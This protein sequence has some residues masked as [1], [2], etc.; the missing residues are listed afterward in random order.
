MA[1]LLLRL[2]NSDYFSPHLALLRTY[3]DHVGITYYLI[4]KLCEDFPQD[5]VEF[6][7]PQYCHLLVTKP[8]AS[9][10][11]ECFLLRKCEEDVHIAL[12]TLWYIQAQLADLAD[13]P[14]SAAFRTCQRVYNRCQCIL[15]EDPDP[16]AGTRPR[17]MLQRFLPHF[18][19][20]KRVRPENVSSALVGIGA[21]LIGSPGC[22]SA[23]AY[24]G[25]LALQQGRRAPEGIEAHE[26]WIPET[27]T[28]LAEPLLAPPPSLVHVTPPKEHD[29]VRDAFGQEE[30]TR[31]IPVAASASTPA[32][33]SKPSPKYTTAS[34]SSVSDAPA[35]D[36]NSYSV[37][38]RKQYLRTHYGRT[39]TQ[40]LQALQDITQ[41]LQPL[42]K[43][44]RLSALRAELTALNHK[45][46]TELC[47]PTWCA[48]TPKEN[49]P[50]ERH[51]RVVRISASEAVVL[52]SAD[53]VPYLIHVEVLCNDLD[54]DP[55]RRY[56]RE[57]LQWL[58][59]NTA[60]HA[61]PLL[62]PRKDTQA[63]RVAETVQ[64]RPPS[65]ARSEE[66]DLTEQ[67]YGSDLAAFGAETA[68]GDGDEGMGEKNHALDNEAWRH[69]ESGP[70]QRVPFS[71]DEYAERMR[72]AA[73]MLAQL[74]GNTSTRQ[75][76]AHIPATRAPQSWSS[77]II[78]TPAAPDDEVRA[79]A[80][81]AHVLSMDTNKIRQR[82]MD[83]MAALEEER[84][85][86][87]KQGA[88]SF[89]R[90]KRNKF[91]AEDE[92]AVYRAVNKEDPSAAYF[93]ESWTTK[94]ERIRSLSPYGHLP[95][96]DLFSV[97]VKTGADLRQE[98]FAVQLIQEFK[99]VWQDCGSRCWVHYF[100]IVVL[101]E[102][103]GLIETIKDAVSVHSI[104]K[105]AYM[106]QM[107]G[108]AIASFSLYDHFV[109]TYGEPHTPRFR[110][111]R[112][113]FTESLAGYAIVS[114]L[115]QIKDRHN[116]NILVDT[117]GH[118]IHID[119]GFILGISPGGVGFEAAPF[120]L[121][122]EYIDIM[123][124]MESDGFEDFRTL[125]RQ[126]F[127]D[128]RKHAERFIVLVEL[129]QKDSKLPCF[130]LRDLAVANL[131]DRFQLTLTAEQCNEFVDRLI[132]SSAGSAFTRLYDQYQNFTQQIL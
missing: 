43:P 45:L 103:G 9:R 49:M 125:M 32:L 120:K 102:S 4:S 123:G 116:G 63:P 61:A 23:G 14:G 44:A 31:P 122:R 81:A 121:P 89:G 20:R 79:S 99:R 132:L 12:I 82:I 47:F 54:F 118:L 42:P 71:M 93:R 7:W 52:N 100:R 38:V 15:F 80:A 21:L 77:W 113:N 119:F 17:S 48:G 6:Y 88:L 67:M 50:H 78:G 92:S 66:M 3:S 97:I 105:E 130:A 84:M 109:Q 28:L 53:R 65:P 106:S 40:F 73:V 85:E 101:S 11:L 91:S 104:K 41:R 90:R 56:N 86:R 75:V 35:P 95:T 94:K 36:A 10:A 72:T 57:L 111:A 1:S 24:A 117:E 5:Q 69:A 68:D 128:V 131:R 55:T 18:E 76:M 115:L 60:G 98:Q 127:R 110:R 62:L 59:G 30:R 2:F 58:I 33:P 112:R 70:N 124:G 129:M 107:E 13:A 29:F 39:V 96:W 22:P 126:G 26:P 27:D 8:S 64:E 46:P 34:S 108:N 74:N 19:V 114:Y 37:A 16:E 25:A 87:M 83:E 51:H